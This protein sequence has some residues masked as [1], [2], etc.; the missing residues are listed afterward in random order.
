MKIITRIFGMSIMLFYV[1]LIFLQMMDY[2][3]R[4][5]EL[6]EC[7]SL[8]MTST[9]IV[10]MENIEDIVYGTNN[11]RKKI[12]S[13]DAYIQ[14]FLDNFT[15]LVSTKTKYEVKVYAIDYK[16]GLLSVGIEGK[17][18]TLNGVEKTFSS[19]KT[20]IIDVLDEGDMDGVN[21]ISY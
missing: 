8:A 9:Q 16:L 12:S 7:L 15:L 5:N 11:C 14:E 20:S 4:R 6:N 13:N 10:M 18:Q 2:N 3:I 19:R 17:F 1:I 21:K